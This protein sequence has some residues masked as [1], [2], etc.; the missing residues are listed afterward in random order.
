MRAGRVTL[1]GQPVVGTG[2]E[3][4]PFDSNNTEN[5]GLPIKAAKYWNSSPTRP[6]H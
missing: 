6:T 5:E 4:S 3:G 1:F 2:D